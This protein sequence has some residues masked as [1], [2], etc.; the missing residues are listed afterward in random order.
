MCWAK[1]CG[2]SYLVE[3][4]LLNTTPPGKAH[5]TIAGL[6]CSNAVLTDILTGP[7]IAEF[8]LST[9]RNAADS[10]LCGLCGL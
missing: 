8:P 2:Q 6:L 9:C 4:L 1:S 3:C 5:C 7:V 10:I